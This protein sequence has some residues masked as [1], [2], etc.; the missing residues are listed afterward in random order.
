MNAM[1]KCKTRL[2]AAA[3]ISMMLG[4][5]A[6]VMAT[7]T[8]RNAWVTRYATAPSGTSASYT[9]MLNNCNLCHANGGGSNYNAYG[10]ALKQQIDG[11]ASTTT[12]LANVEHLNSDGVSGDNLAEIL[13]STQP[14]W[15]SGPNNTIRI[16]NAGTTQTNQNPAALA[17]GTYDIPVTCP[18]DINGDHSVNVADLLSVISA[19]GACP[20]PPATCPADINHDLQV[21]VADLLT[22]ISTWGACP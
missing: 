15:T 3:A 1:R 21:N 14:G 12:A 9:N 20:A 7:N 8:I 16:D 13:A 10:W 6:H 2:M 11:G 22:V 18:A 19:W 4:L 17:A 5:S